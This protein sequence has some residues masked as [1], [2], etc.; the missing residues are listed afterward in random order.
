MALGFMTILSVFIGA[1]F[2]AAPEAFKT[3]HPVGKYVGFTLLVFFALTSLK[4]AIFD[5]YKTNNKE[6]E[7]KLF[8]LNSWILIFKEN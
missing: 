3:N 4:D 7:G 6:K 5:N 2:K 8:K 1:C